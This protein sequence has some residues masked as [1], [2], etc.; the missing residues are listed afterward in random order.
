MYSSRFVRVCRPCAGG[1]LIFSVS[2]KV[3]R[4][5]SV[6]Y[7]P[8]YVIFP[9]PFQFHR[10]ISVEYPTVPR[11]H[12]RLRCVPRSTGGAHSR[13]GHLRGAR[14]WHPIVLK[15]VVIVSRRTTTNPLAAIHTHVPLESADADQVPH[16]KNSHKV[17]T[18]A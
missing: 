9:A 14:P 4:M 18:G 16:T 2:F 5:I 8:C 17:N 12:L 11:R 15:L 1:M 10:M 3:V 6:E 13:S 7:G